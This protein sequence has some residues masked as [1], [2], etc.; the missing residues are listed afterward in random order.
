MQTGSLPQPDPSRSVLQVSVPLLETGDVM[1]GRY[2]ILQLLGE[3]GMGAVY[4]ARDRELDR[5]VA[6]ETDSA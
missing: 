1:A 5:F 3:G 4:K 6:F 2:E